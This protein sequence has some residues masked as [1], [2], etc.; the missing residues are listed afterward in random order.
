[1]L[2][3]VSKYVGTHIAKLNVKILYEHGFV[4]IRRVGV[5]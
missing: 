5:D 3:I 1:M 4:Y 2:K